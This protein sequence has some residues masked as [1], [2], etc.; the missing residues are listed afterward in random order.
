LPKT[1]IEAFSDGVFAIVITLMAFDIK[2]APNSNDLMEALHALAPKLNGYI[3]SFALVGM[4]WIA[5][6]QMFHAF[7]RVNRQLMWINLLFLLF[8]TFLPFTT[9]LLSVGN[10]SQNA[11]MIYGGNLAI[12]SLVMFGMWVYATRVADLAESKL[13]PEMRRDVD[14]RI[15][16]MPLLA[17]A[18][19]ALSY[20][21]VRYS[22]FV[23]YAI[24]IR[25][26]S[27]RRLDR[28]LNANPALPDRD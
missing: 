19:I 9:S 22:L 25:F 15:L 1:R 12:I 6:H 23:Y 26:L 17:I 21:S 24:V 10:I 14:W 18:S 20:Y 8:V 2:L 16:S 4:Y 27:A 5:H 11:V 3:L 13:T 7:R 28:H